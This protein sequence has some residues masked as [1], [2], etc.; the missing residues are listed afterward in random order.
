MSILLPLQDQI[1]VT[2]NLLLQLQD[3]YLKSL[4]DQYQTLA[5]IKLNSGDASFVKRTCKESMEKCMETLTPFKL[6]ESRA[7]EILQTSGLTNLELIS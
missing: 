3:N 4:E 6:K 2:Y 7:I 1:N 5:A